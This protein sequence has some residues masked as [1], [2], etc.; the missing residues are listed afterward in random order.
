MKSRFLKWVLGLL[1]IGVLM[2]PAIRESGQAQPAVWLTSYD[3]ALKIARQTGK[4]ILMDFQADWCGPCHMLREQV[5]DA[6]I[7]K[8]QAD[9][10]VLL[11][12]DVEK[13]RDLQMKYQA[14]SLPTILVLNSQGKPVLGRHGYAGP[15]DMLQLLETAYTRATTPVS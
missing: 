5:F 9:R 2:L 8:P 15:D 11:T 10:W 1:L 13:H 3:E 7:F 6:P 14:G 4:P 12:I